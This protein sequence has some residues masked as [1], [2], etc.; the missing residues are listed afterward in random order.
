MSTGAD[1]QEIDWTQVDLRRATAQERLFYGAAVR[2]LRHARDMTQ[3]DLAFAANVSPR[4][5]R[6]I[7]RGMV[8][9]QV[10]VLERLFRALDIQLKGA[11][12]STSTQSWM[13]VIGPLLEVL[14]EPKR[15][16]VVQRVLSML[17]EA[18]QQSNDP[19]PPGSQGDAAGAGGG[20]EK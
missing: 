8:T 16:V 13:A 19:T 20:V 9:G 1:G 5:I 15:G 6:N 10:D 4:T 7:E 2:D 17:A 3:E 14:P 18:I 11:A 12:L